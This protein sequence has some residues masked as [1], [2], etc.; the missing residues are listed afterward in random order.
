MTMV[1]EWLIFN[2]V[3]LCADGTRMNDNDLMLQY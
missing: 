2:E 1:L 3:H